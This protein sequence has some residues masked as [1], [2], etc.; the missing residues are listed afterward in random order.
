MG[1][2]GPHGDRSVHAQAAAVR[3]PRRRPPPADLRALI[4]K[5]ARPRA[6]PR[7]AH[8]ALDL[9]GIRATGP[10]KSTAA[11][12]GCPVTRAGQAQGLAGSPQGG[13]SHRRG[14]GWRKPSPLR[15]SASAQHGPQG[16]VRRRQGCKP[17]RAE[18]A[19]GLGSRQPDPKK[20]G[21]PGK[22]TEPS[23]PGQRRPAQG[24]EKRHAHAH[25]ARKSRP[26]PGSRTTAAKPERPL[27]NRRRP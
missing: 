2:D 22:D 24:P 1:A 13:P 15:A 12:C 8:A 17:V 19:G 6:A 21:R 16:P 25:G 10:N 20:G 11:V 4:S 27:K 7:A 14:G 26:R 23:T 18:T 3:G 5:T 9:H